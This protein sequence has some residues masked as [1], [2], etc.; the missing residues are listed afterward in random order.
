MY[1][2][3]LTKFTNFISSAHRSV[4]DVC[5]FLILHTFSEYAPRAIYLGQVSPNGFLEKKASFGFE[6]SY[7][8]QWERIPLTAHFPII[9]AIRRDEVL[10]F[11]KEEFFIG[12]PQIHELGVVDRDWESCFVAPIQSIGAFFVVLHESH[13]ARPEFTSFLR[14]LG[15]LL[16][17]HLDESVIHQLL[18]KKPSNRGVPLSARQEIIRTLA[19]K[20]FS[21]R[22]IAQEIGYSESLVR[23]ETISIYSSLGISGRD[24]LIN[25][26]S[27]ETS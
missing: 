27:K 17:L 20:G 24:E 3:E 9:D 11:S 21:N 4:E 25:D 15:H 7:V 14:V 22:A 2:A 23:Q 1:F 12:Y 5:K 26:E 8:S 19:A 13:S 6:Q 10:L 16:A 18:E